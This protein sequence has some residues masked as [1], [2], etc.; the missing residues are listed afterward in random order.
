M[1]HQWKLKIFR[2]YERILEDVSKALVAWASSF[3]GY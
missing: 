2:C 3:A 1:F